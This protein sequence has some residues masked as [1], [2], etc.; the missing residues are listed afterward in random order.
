MPAND[1]TN[2]N[3]IESLYSLDNLV[4]EVKLRRS[5]LTPH[6]NQKSLPELFLS[7]QAY[8]SVRKV[9]QIILTLLAITVDSERS[10][11]CMGRVKTLRLPM[12]S[13]RLRSP[14]TSDRLSELCVLHCHHERVDEAKTNR[15]L[16]TMAGESDDELISEPDELEVKLIQLFFDIFICVDHLLIW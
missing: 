16:A 11:L 7:A 8:P 2:I 6:V 13:D 1:P 9:I 12:T 15:I 5:A 10:F 14:M 4:N 3:D